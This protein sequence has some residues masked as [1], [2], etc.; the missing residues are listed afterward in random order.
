MGSLPDE[1]SGSTPR[2]RCLGVI[3]KR[4]SWIT[5]TAVFWDQSHNNFQRSLPERFSGTTLGAIFWD[6]S[7]KTYNQ[8][9]LPKQFFG[10]TPNQFYGEFY[11]INPITILWDHPKSNFLG[12]LGLITLRV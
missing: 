5:P 7:Q 3:P 4:V 1:V 9:S 8:E 2:D 12:S 6:H 11:G 10:I